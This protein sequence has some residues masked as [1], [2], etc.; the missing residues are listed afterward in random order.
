MKSSSYKLPKSH[1]GYPEYQ[2]LWAYPSSA[3]LYKHLELSW[4][5]AQP[6]EYPRAVPCYTHRLDW[7]RDD[8]GGIAEHDSNYDVQ[9]GCVSRLE[10][11]ASP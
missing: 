9:K 5:K 6:R 10:A 3:D 4:L 7:P 1:L 2:L 11:D 8:S